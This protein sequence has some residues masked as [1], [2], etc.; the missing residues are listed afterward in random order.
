MQLTPKKTHRQMIGSQDQM[1]VPW[2]GPPHGERGAFATSE[3]AIVLP[4]IIV[5]MFTTIELCSVIFI[6]EALTV[7]AYEA[8]RVAIQR[9]ITRAQAVAAGEQV[10]ENRD[11]VTGVSPVQINPDPTTASIMQPITVTASA[12][13]SGNTI[14][15]LIVYKVFG[16]PNITTT[17]VMRKEFSD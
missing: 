8:G 11:I 4:V 7:A 2:S 9:R 3:C 5:I 16:K 14:I 13:V 1:N 6:K 17:V 12:P 15:P 10:L